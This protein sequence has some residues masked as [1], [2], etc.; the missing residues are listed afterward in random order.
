MPQAS[1]FTPEQKGNT[2]TDPVAGR[3]PSAA[4]VEKFHTNADT[5]GDEGSIHHTLGPGRGQAASG[6]HAH[7]GGSSKLLGVGYT[8]TG[9]KGG[10]V[11]L[12]NVLTFLVDKFGITDST[13]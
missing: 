12:A 4:E 8:I 5:D 2:P 11:A 7:D 9:A 10:N 6:D 3:L 13:T 1:G